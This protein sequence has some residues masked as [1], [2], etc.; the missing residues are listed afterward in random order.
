MKYEKADDIQM[1][2]ADIVLKLAWSMLEWMMLFALEVMGSSSRRTIARCH[3]LN[4][5]MPE[6]SWKD[7]D[8]MFS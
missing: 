2:M 6:S 1:R 8:F 3:A 5:V 7:R 4:K